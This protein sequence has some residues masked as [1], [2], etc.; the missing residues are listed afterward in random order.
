MR[1]T[2]HPGHRVASMLAVVAVLFAF[3]ALAG[4]RARAAERLCD[5][6]RFRVELARAQSI[7]TSRESDVAVPLTASMDRR[8]RSRVDAAFHRAACLVS[9]ANVPE[10]ELN[11]ARVLLAKSGFKDANLEA[12]EWRARLRTI[13]TEMTSCLR[14]DPGQIEC[15]MWHAASRGRLA[16]SSWNPLNI[17]LPSELIQEFHRARGGLPSGR[18]PDGAATR[19]E[20]SM[21]LKAPRLLGGDPAAGRKLI[22]EA[23]AVPGFPCRLTNRLIV[24]EA[25]GRTGDWAAARRELQAI[26]AGGLPSC[27]TEHYENAVSLAKAARCLSRLDLAHPSD[28]IWN[29][30]C[31]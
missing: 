2:K 24:A 3:G 14:S 8:Y 5:C 1:D 16:Q 29:D 20:A 26:V 9:C 10:A 13:S 25:L 6:N 31:R 21:L 4:F 28:A 12:D 19:G 17:R 11:R 22:E 7:F 27:G 30:D 23:S 18:D 15:L